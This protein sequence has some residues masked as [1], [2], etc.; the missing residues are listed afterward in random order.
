MTNIVRGVVVANLQ[1]SERGTGVPRPPR[2]S[3]PSS[4]AFSRPRR[5]PACRL[6]Q[7]EPAPVG[8]CAAVLYL[9][10][11]RPGRLWSLSEG[12]RPRDYRRTMG[13][14]RATVVV[15]RRL[16]AV[17][18]PTNHARTLHHHDPASCDLAD[19][20]SGGFRG[21]DGP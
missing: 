8:G 2:H 12:T 17:G 13:N 7:A 9:S 19:H 16:L 4:L 20:L 10:T 5:P 18:S 14:G 3:R 21:L 15:R 1:C 11:H 6:R